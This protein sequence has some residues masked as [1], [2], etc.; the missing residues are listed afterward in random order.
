MCGA[1]FGCIEEIIVVDVTTECKNVGFMY[2]L[3]QIKKL[4]DTPW[5]YG[6][7]LFIM[8]SWC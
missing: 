3:F 7:I 6:G 1:N 4:N 5:Q 8:S 2:Q